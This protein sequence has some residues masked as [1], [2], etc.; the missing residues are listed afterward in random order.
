MVDSLSVHL[1]PVNPNYGTECFLSYWALQS[2]SGHHAK[3]PI[4]CH[5]AS[6]TELQFTVAVWGFDRF[7]LPKL[8]ARF[9]TFYR[10]LEFSQKS[11]S[12]PFHFQ[13]GMTSP[14][15][16]LGGIH[17]SFEQCFHKFHLQ[18]NLT[19]DKIIVQVLSVIFY[20]VFAHICIGKNMYVYIFS[21]IHV[22]FFNCFQFFCELCSD[23]FPH[24]SNPQVQV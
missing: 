10:H 11:I 13:L 6:C 17:R 18:S 19:Q 8:S 5:S 16:S 20:I 4:P 23:R 9:L 24:V 21:H 12:Q 15:F 22:R 1:F 2:D 14:F 7:K 3:L